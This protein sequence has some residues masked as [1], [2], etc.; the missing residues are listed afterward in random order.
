MKKFNTF[1]V[2]ALIASVGAVLTYNYHTFVEAR[3]IEA[4]LTLHYEILNGQALSPYNYR[5]LVPFITESFSKLLSNFEFISYKQSWLL[6]YILYDYLCITLFLFTLFLFLRQWHSFTMSLSGVMFCAA[7][8]PISLRDHYFQPWSLLEAGLFCAALLA[9][10]KK[11]YLL[12]LGITIVASLNRI[13]GLFVPFIYL[14][15]T[16]DMKATIEKINRKILSQFLKFIGL[17]VVSISIAIL[18]RYI[19]GFSA[20]IHTISEIWKMNTS[21]YNLLV[22]LFHITLFAG[23]VWIFALLGLRHADKFTRQEALLVPIY[24]VPVIIFGV[25]KEV[26]LLMPLYPIIISLGLFYVK[27]LPNFF[28]KEDASS[29]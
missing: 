7:L 13:T 3:Y 5:V 15:G 9:T 17:I 20:S 26:R 14:L 18:L 16:L 12:I 23:V 4:R 22:A 2:L 27:S 24:L 1:L 21:P 29:T 10:L 25:W 19:Q 28:C 8:L 11:R 6:A